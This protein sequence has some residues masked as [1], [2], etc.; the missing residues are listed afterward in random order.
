MKW[1]QVDEWNAGFN[2]ITLSNRLNID[3]DYFHRMTKNAVIA[4]LL[5]FSTTTLAGNY[6]KILNSGFDINLSWDDK[7]N[8]DFSYH[9]GVNMS[10]LRNRVKELNGHSIISGGKTVN[11]VGKE[12]NSFY[13]LMPTP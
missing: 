10:T 9:V 12:M 6:G 4:P 13:G 2:L 5:P 11:I 3:V 8:K 7:L 1:E